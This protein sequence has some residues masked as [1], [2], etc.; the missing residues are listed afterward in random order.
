MKK[1]I[2][3]ILTASAV[4]LIGT[5]SAF[6]ASSQTGRGFVDTNADGICDN[7]GTLCCN[8]AASCMSNNSDDTDSEE[9]ISHPR[10]GKAAGPQTGKGFVDANADGVCDNAGTLCCHI[11]AGSVPNNR[12]DTDSEENID[13]PRYSQNR[14]DTNQDGVCDYTA[15]CQGTKQHQRQ[16]YRGGHNR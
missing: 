4:L 1:T 13:Q 5:A 6:A 8:I 14:S 9:N 3:G 16:G 11:A 2:I 15:V 7:A 12:N 10:Y